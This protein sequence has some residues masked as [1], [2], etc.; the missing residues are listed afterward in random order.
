MSFLVTSEVFPTMVR[1]TSSGLTM[2]PG[3][4]FMIFYGYVMNV[5]AEKFPWLSPLIMGAL[6]LVSAVASLALPE[7]RRVILLQTIEETEAYYRNENTLLAKFFARCQTSKVM[8]T[9]I[10]HDN[11]VQENGSV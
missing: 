9:S 6:S 5:S 10:N 8:P 11:K 4:I 2:I 1:A 7:T 3:R